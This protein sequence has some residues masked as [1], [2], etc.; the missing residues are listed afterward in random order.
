MI[1][2]EIINMC[3]DSSVTS[4]DYPFDEDFETAE[5]LHDAL[6]DVVAFLVNVSFGIEIF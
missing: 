6:A 5:L 1:K 3:L 4:P 2:Q